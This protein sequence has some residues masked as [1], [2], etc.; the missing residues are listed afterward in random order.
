MRWRTLLLELCEIRGRIARLVRNTRSRYSTFDMSFCADLEK[1]RDKA[2]TI[3][4]I[5]YF[6]AS[7]QR[8]FTHLSTPHNLPPHLLAC[9]RNIP[10]TFAKVRPPLLRASP[11]FVDLPVPFSCIRFCSSSRPTSGRRPWPPTRF[12]SSRARARALALGTTPLCHHVSVR[13]SISST[14]A[15]WIQ[16]NARDV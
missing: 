5:R 9:L 16:W 13:R 15:R 4:R 6:M 1:R 14:V 7:S 10:R 2:A 11:A 12:V 3:Y 8:T